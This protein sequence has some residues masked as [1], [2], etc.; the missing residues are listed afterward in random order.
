MKFKVLLVGSLVAIGAM[1]LLA[2]NITEKEKERV[3][4]AK[5]PSQAGIEGKAKSE[6]WA[7][8]YPRQFDSWKKT[9]EGDQ[10][11]DMLSKKPY[12]AVAWAGYPF[13]KSI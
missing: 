2:G 9:K 8:Y 7:K 13:S 5:A 10:L 4:L 1:A 6:E 12:L 11:E 3:E